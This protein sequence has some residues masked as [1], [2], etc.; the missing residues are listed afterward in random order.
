[1]VSPARRRTCVEHVVRE[2]GV[3]E[4][5]LLVRFKTGRNRVFLKVWN[6]T[7]EMFFSM[8]LTTAVGNPSF[9][10]PSKETFSLATIVTLPAFPSP[11]VLAF[12]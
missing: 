10:S 4:R 9:L 8:V 7:Q 5:Q 2:L 12:N 6:D 3:S 11:K 1:M